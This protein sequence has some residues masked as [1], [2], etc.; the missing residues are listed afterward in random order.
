MET[1]LAGLQRK[2]HSCSFSPAERQDRTAYG[3]LQDHLI[4]TCVREDIADIKPAQQ[5]LRQEVHRYNLPPGS[6]NHQEIPYFRFQRALREKRSLFR[7]SKSRPPS[8]PQKISFAPDGSN[9]RPFIRYISINSLQF[10][11]HANQQNRSTSAFIPSMTKSLR[12]DS[13]AREVS[14]VQKIKKLRSRGC[15]LL[16]CKSVQL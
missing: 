9:R 5:V 7:S 3:W 11:V 10:K 16:N 15:A 13:G 8:N 2:R 1:G 14:H 12:S 6:L 4:R